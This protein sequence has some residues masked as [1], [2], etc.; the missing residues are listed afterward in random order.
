MVSTASPHTPAHP[1]IAPSAPTLMDGPAA[2]AAIPPVGTP[3]WGP[4]GAIGTLAG[5]RTPAA[6][7]AADGGPFL[8]VRLSHLLGLRHSTHVVPATWVQLEGVSPA[9]WS[10]IS[11][12]GRLRLTA[13]RAQVAGCPRVRP[14][15]HIRQDVARALVEARLTRGGPPCTRPFSTVSWSSPATRLGRTA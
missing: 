1:T 6:G 14:D 5:A 9:G 8:L 3:V 2:S 13:D 11:H 12:P 7:T 4:D 15:A 10:Q